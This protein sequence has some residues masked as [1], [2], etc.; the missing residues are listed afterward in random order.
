MPTPE[1]IAG[2]MRVALLGQKVAN[3][4]K[5]SRRETQ[6][7]REEKNERIYILY[8]RKGVVKTGQGGWTARQREKIVVYLYSRPVQGSHDSQYGLSPTQCIRTLSSST[9]ARTAI[10]GQFLKVTTPHEGVALIS[11]SR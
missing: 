6:R 8:D 3:E 9:M 7:R 10:D 11:M 2:W 5:E 4:K 1:P